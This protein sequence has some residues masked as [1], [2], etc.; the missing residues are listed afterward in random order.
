MGAAIADDDTDRELRRFEELTC[1]HP[2]PLRSR[3]ARS[4]LCNLRRLRPPRPGSLLA[5]V[6]A[7]RD[8]GLVRDIRALRLRQDVRHQH[9]RAAMQRELLAAAP[10][11]WTVRIAVDRATIRSNIVFPFPSR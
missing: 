3:A 11:E 9:V 1:G 4:P 6:Q 8:A 5:R 2:R 10:P 7:R